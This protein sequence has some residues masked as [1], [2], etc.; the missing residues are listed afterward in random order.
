M[1]Q[2]GEPVY[3]A[4]MQ[5]ISAQKLT[6]IVKSHLEKGVGGRPLRSIFSFSPYEKL[7]S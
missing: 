5:R 7:P 1:F 4:L 3:T 2:P 6:D